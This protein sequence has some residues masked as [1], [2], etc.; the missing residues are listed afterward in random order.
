MPLT[1]PQTAAAFALAATLGT[2]TAQAGP[3]EECLSRIASDWAPTATY[4][5]SKVSFTGNTT[6]LYAVPRIVRSTSKDPVLVQPPTTALMTISNH[7]T[8]VSYHNLTPEELAGL[9][10]KVTADHLDEMGFLLPASRETETFPDMVYARNAN[11]KWAK[12]TLAFLDCL[13][14]ER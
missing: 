12:F 1:I 6:A 13:Q 8:F 14:L 11:P 5:A 10:K 3:Q 7:M 2:G 9:G 4:L